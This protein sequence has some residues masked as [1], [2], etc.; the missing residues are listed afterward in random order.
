MKNVLLILSC[1]FPF[2][3]FSQQKTEV[4]LYDLKIDKE[5]VILLNSLNISNNV[6][7]D[8]QPSFI[9]KNTIAFSSTNNEQTDIAIYDIKAKSKSWVSVT[10]SSEFSPVKIPNKNAVSVIRQGLDNSQNLV[11]YSLEDATETVLIDSL[12]I[13]YYTWVDENIVA[14]AILED[15]S[16]SLNFANLENNTNKTVLKNIGRSLHKIPKSKL[17]SYINKESSPWEIR[18]YDYTT[19]TSE[20][21]V[22]TVSDSEDICWTPNGTI[23]TGNGLDLLKFNPK[24]DSEWV[25]IGTL[26]DKKLS[27]ITRLNMNKN[28]SRL[29]LVVD[30]E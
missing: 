14:L 23:I 29:V 11:S 20:F 4:Y 5:Y 9:D 26:S 8:N 12:L 7:Y 16:L 3:C 18:S 28:S 17:I 24:T 1:F 15:N 27:N 2:F 21:I 19:N 30:Q 22:N 25:N 10:E 13:G 6:G